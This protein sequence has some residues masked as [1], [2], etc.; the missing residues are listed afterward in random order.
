MDDHDI[1][2]LT[3][4]TDYDCKAQLIAKPEVRIEVPEDIWNDD[5]VS[6]G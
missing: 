5:S 3:A 1:Q 6:I 4:F 2:N